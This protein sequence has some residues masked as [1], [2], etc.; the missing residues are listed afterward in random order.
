MVKDVVVAETV[1]SG[2]MGDNNIGKVI[3][4]FIPANRDFGEI[5]K[6]LIDLT[7]RFKGPAV[8]GEKHL[9]GLLY[10]NVQRIGIK[11]SNSKS[12]YKKCTIFKKKYLVISTL[13]QDGK[14]DVYKA[15]YFKTFMRLAKCVIKE[16][17]RLML[18]DE[19]GR[20]IKHRLEWQVKIQKELFGIIHIPEVIDLFESDGNIYFVMEFIKGKPLTHKINSIYNL[21]RWLQLSGK[22][23]IE[24]FDLFLQL[25][26]SLEKIHQR[27]YVHRDLSPLNFLVNEGG[28]LNIID[29]ELA[30]NVNIKYPLPPFGVGTRGFMSPEQ[31]AFKVPTMKEDI[32]GLGS[33]MIGFFANLPAAKYDFDN[34]DQIRNDMFSSTGNLQVA[35][36]IVSCL[37]E[38]PDQRPE[39]H[40]IKNVMVSWRDNCI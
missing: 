14:G 28:Q 17:K 16:G 22:E 33:L 24:L 15:L 8:P 38:S 6:K 21:R 20:D 12:G 19:Y 39:L 1:M 3:L 5:I 32:F 7:Q 11:S 27:G 23:K 31:R 26:N 13:K 2:L 29:M 4:F 18:A 30:Y 9:G 36:L 10:L 34:L 37:N 40:E 25:I 35:E